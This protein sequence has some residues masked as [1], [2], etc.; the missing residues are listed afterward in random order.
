[1]KIRS[2]ER[3]GEECPGGSG[4]FQITF[5]SGPNSVGSPVLV[6]TPV[7][8]GPRNCSQSSADAPIETQ[9]ISITSIATIR[10]RLIIRFIFDLYTAKRNF[11][12]AHRSKMGLCAGF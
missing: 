8:F 10:I 12:A 6:D 3:T 7:P 5:L 1:M 9:V 2:R 4:V 11:L